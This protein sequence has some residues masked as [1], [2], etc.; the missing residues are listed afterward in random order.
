MKKL[1]I[2][3][4]LLFINAGVYAQQ[5][6]PAPQKFALVIGN[7][8]YTN[9][10]RLNNPVND[11]EDIAAVLQGLGFTVDKVLNGS[12]DQM[13]S[14]IMR[15]R[16]QLSVSSNS[17]GFFF[18]AGHGVQSGGANYLI[19]VNA[20]IPGESF[21]R[22][23]A[24]SVQALLQELNDARNELNIVV[25][26]ACRDNPF[27]WARSGSRGLTVVS[28]QPADSIIVFSTI[29]G[30]VASDGTGRNGIFTGSLLK[31]LGNPALEISEV[32]RL[33]G[34]DVAQTSNRQQI[35]AVY[36]QFFGRA[37][38]GPSS[39]IPAQAATSYMP[40]VA[41]TSSV[42]T[43]PSVS[44]APAP[45][46]A[47]PVSFLD[48][49]PSYD[50]RQVVVE[51]VMLGGVQYRDAL[52]LAT[53][54]NGYSLHNL[55]GRYSRFSGRIGRVDGTSPSDTTINFYG[56]GLLLRA[57]NLKANDLPME[58]SLETT[59][60]RQLKIEFE[61]SGIFSGSPKYALINAF[62]IP[63]AEATIPVSPTPP[64]TS[65]S[66]LDTA[67]SYDRNEVHPSR[68]AESWR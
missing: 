68:L 48:A 1:F 10:G 45:A 29:A 46:S 36:N 44:I 23:R 47:L 63:S 49:A 56:D 17:Y 32:F 39:A 55:N 15:L 60:I 64:T 42:P 67:S 20:N 24:V 19:P 30:S 6:D 51:N 18:Y 22:E 12:L 16:N 21:L 40:E 4:I 37:F 53:E 57:F 41:K 25:L 5:G 3:I 34:A 33:T 31:N 8:A 43:L 54:N 2:I 35:P 65:V 7:G 27:S 14:A 26:D 52:V 66:I 58:I 13:E 62:L 9:L 28:G 11:A 61:G 59:G 38:L 50:R